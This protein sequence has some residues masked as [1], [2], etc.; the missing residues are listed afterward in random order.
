MR[1]LHKL[2][3]YG[4]SGGTLSWIKEFLSEGFQQVVLE[5]QNLSRKKYSPRHPRDWLGSLLFL[6]FINDLPDVVKTS[7]V[8]LLADY[9]LLYHHIRNHKDSADLQTDLS[10][11]ED[12]ET[13]W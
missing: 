7:E 2:N 4:I 1:L 8:R 9:C 10:A 6:V 11:L 12:W 13:K 5:G 3:Y